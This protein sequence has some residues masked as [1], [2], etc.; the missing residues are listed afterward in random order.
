M[1]RVFIV[2]FLLS[3]VTFAAFA[4]STSVN[5]ADLPGPLPNVFNLPVPLPFPIP[6]YLKRQLPGYLVNKVFKVTSNT[7]VVTYE[8]GVYKGT[9]HKML[10]FSERGRLLR[11]ENIRQEIFER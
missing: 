3:Q 1:R 5:V 2:M 8:I 11:S 4:Q 10:L 7:K 9:A 6:D